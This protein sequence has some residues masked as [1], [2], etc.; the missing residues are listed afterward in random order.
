MPLASRLRFLLS[1]SLAAALSLPIPG[2][3]RAAETGAHAH[4]AR[5][6]GIDWFDG[7]PAAAFAQA[8]ATGKP[9]FLYWGAVWCPPCQE[10][11]ATIFQRQ[12]FRDRLHEFVPVFLDGDGAGAQAWGE[13]FHVLGYP[14]VL[15]LR[16]DQTEVERVS[17][18]M[19]LARYAEVL[20]LALGQVRPVKELLDGGGQ[21]SA[22]DCRRLAYNA[23]SLDDDW[24]LHPE[25]LG[26]LADRLSQ[27]AARC[28][29]R[30]DVERARL[31]MTAVHAAVSA[32]QAALKGGAA[33]DAALQALLAKVPAILAD[34]ALAERIGDTLFF[35]PAEFFPAAAGVFATGGGDAGRDALRRRWFERMDALAGDPRYSAADRMDAVRSKLLAAKALSADGKVPPAIAAAATQRIDRELAGERE[36]YARTSLVNEALNALDVLD[37]DRRAHDILSAEARTSA[38]GYYYMADL[39]ELEEKLGHPD[40]AVQWLARSYREAQGPATRFQWGV[41]YVRGL[42][43]MRPQ[44]EAAIREAALSVLG[45]LD[46]AGDLHGRTL[47]SLR[48]LEAS[49]RD[50]DKD[51]SHAGA[52]GA[53]RDRVAA[54]CGHLPADDSSRPACESFLAGA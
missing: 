53:L 15:V 13:R 17:G 20:D 19:D 10:L 37:D 44:D 6:A 5:P 7:D 9:V 34:G 48:R 42:V 14:T 16:A 25:S 32:R 40:L 26:S 18:G 3:A 24:I 22:D 54:I 4:G 39:G 46:A 50:W 28:P 38:Y 51:A 29:V 35:M 8:S 33:P 43:R 21:F 30:L 49:L 12:D 11:K 45:E 1:L 23:W 36:P 52:I 41:G 27:A 47:R 31:Q 2:G